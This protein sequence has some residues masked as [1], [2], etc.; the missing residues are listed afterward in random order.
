MNS[1]L[2]R[3]SYSCFSLALRLS[4]Y[5]LRRKLFLTASRNYFEFCYSNTFSSAW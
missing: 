5:T 3:F 1:P 2:V 4:P